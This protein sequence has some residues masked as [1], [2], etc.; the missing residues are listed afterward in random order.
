MSQPRY[1]AGNPHAEIAKY[2]V[3]LMAEQ[4]QE[5]VVDTDVAEEHSRIRPAQF[6]CFELRPRTNLQWTR[7]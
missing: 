6:R 1:A 3:P 7:F 5:A 2:Q 4:S